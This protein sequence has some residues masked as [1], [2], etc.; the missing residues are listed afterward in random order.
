MI[1]MKL[2]NILVIMLENNMKISDNAQLCEN[3]EEKDEPIDKSKEMP[4]KKEPKKAI[5]FYDVYP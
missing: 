2:L 3:D 4:L 1:L 5:E